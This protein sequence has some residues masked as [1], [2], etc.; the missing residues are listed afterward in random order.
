MTGSYRNKAFHVTGRVQY[1][2]PSGALW[3][4]WYLSFPGERW[5]WL[6]EAQGNDEKIREKVRAELALDRAVACDLD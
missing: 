4:E 5:G 3:N 1:K 6:A 2:H